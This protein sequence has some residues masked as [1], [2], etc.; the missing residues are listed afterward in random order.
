MLAAD[1]GVLAIRRHSVQ[2][3]TIECPHTR[4]CFDCHGY[5]RSWNYNSSLADN[6]EDLATIAERFVDAPGAGCCPLEYRLAD[7]KRDGAIARCDGY[8]LWNPFQSS[9]SWTAFKSAGG[10]WVQRLISDIWKMFASSMM[11]TEGV[12]RF[13]ST[14]GLSNFILE[15]DDLWNIGLART[16]V[17]QAGPSSADSGKMLQSGWK[18]GIAT[19]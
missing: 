11:M 3:Q 9:I 14:D 17:M 16:I 6:S 10:A 8:V 4:F 1:T 18:T 5:L 12:C 2:Q 15:L 13:S 19:L 7:R